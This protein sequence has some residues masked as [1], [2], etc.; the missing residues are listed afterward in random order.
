VTFTTFGGR[1]GA[2]L[3]PGQS[4]VVPHGAVGGIVDTGL[5]V[6]MLFGLLGLVTVLTVVG[7]LVIVIVSNRAD[8]DPTG[9]RPLSVYLFGM[10]FVTLLIAVTGSVVVVESLVS[11]IGSHGGIGNAVARGVVLGGLV[12][13]FAEAVLV[14]HLRRGLRFAAADGPAGPSQRIARTYVS[15]VAFVAILFLLLSAI[16]GIYLLCVVAGPGVFGFGISRTVAGQGLIVDAYIAGVALLILWTHRDLVTP[17]LRFFKEQPSSPYPPQ[18][19]YGGPQYGGQPGPYGG[20]PG[21][22]GGQ[23]G[24]Y[25]G[26]HG[27]YGG[28][29][30][31]PVPPP[32]PPAGPQSPP[33]PPAGPPA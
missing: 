26:P 10:S 6:S 13:V 16:G 29:G 33:P 22:Y 11:L 9:R 28:Q 24:P 25:G 3:T 23:P 4:H 32:T 12:M 30:G 15:A 2:L 18:G 31:P 7:V 20:Q 21:T 27:P 19:P 1:S 8:P 5:L 14:V 17:G